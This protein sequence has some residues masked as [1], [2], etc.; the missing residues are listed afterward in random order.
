MVCV[1][2][3]LFAVVACF[4][5]EITKEGV[6]SELLF[7][8]DFIPDKTIKGLRNKFIEWK[9]AFESKC[10]KVNLVKT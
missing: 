7:A 8:D 9:E 5:T 6:L 1:F 3:F 10:L 4:I 2:T